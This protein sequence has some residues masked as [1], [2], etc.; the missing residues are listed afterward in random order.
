MLRE[1]KAL[2]R[3]DHPHVVKVYDAG[4]HGGRVYIAMEFVEGTTLRRF[5][6][7]ASDRSWREI[8]AVY[9]QAGAGVA[10]AHAAEL[11]HRDFKPDNAMLGDDERVRVMD[12]GLARG[13]ND[14]DLE[15]TAEFDAS[16][17]LATLVTRHRL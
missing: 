8:V 13:V 17:P 14:V 5:G 15:T 11:V 9:R 6:R 10:A 7:D 4:N 2:A 3:L 16:D 12:F 1:A